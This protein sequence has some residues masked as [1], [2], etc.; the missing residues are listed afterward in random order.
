MLTCMG[1]KLLPYIQR[2][3]FYYSQCSWFP[4]RFITVIDSLYD[5]YVGRLSLSDVHFVYVMF[6]ELALLQSFRS[7]VVILINFYCC[8]HL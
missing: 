2:A 3:V 4:K 8:F 6:W 7:M 1:Y 5:D